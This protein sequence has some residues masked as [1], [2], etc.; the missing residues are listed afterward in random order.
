MIAK[1]SINYNGI[2]R[3]AARRLAAQARKLF[4]LSGDD[5]V[6]RRHK[7]F[8]VC[9]DKR[10]S[11]FGQ[12]VEKSFKMA[13]EKSPTHEELDDPSRTSKELVGILDQRSLEPIDA[14]IFIDL[15]FKSGFP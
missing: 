14:R 10:L 5:V 2:L 8:S 4:W 12:T 13:S 1:K 11:I 7:P 6:A 3:S 15:D 9:L